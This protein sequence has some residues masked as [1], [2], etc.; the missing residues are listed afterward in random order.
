MPLHAA[1]EAGHN[2]TFQTLP[3]PSPTSNN[4]F[5]LTQGFV[6]MEGRLLFPRTY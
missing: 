3:P 4:G 6:M 2:R 5:T 1:I